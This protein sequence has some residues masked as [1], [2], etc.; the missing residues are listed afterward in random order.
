MHRSS[1]SDL[2][3]P[4]KP[5]SFSGKDLMS[6]MVGATK[7]TASSLA[8]KARPGT[9]RQVTGEKVQFS[10]SGAL[11]ATERIA[12]SAIAKFD[13]LLS[14]DPVDLE[15]LRQLAWQGVPS[16]YRPFVWKLLMG[17]LPCSTDRRE[18]DV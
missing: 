7:R 12:P 14:A 13:Q 6:S 9:V 18:R 4:P 5:N 16:A 2:P 10:G 11:V 3:T 1:D 15:Q 17:Y 8:R